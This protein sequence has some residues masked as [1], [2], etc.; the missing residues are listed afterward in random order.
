MT[1][2]APRRHIST[3]ERVRIFEREGGRCHICGQKIDGTRE[4]WEVEHPIMHAMGGSDKEEDLR[5]AHKR[6]C[7]LEKTKQDLADLAKA[8]RRHARHIGAKAP[9]RNPLPGGRNSR[10]KIKMDGSVV[11]RTR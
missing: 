5:P 11:E 2:R 1:G 10:W 3:A 9:S 6:G 4:A 7:H 8:K